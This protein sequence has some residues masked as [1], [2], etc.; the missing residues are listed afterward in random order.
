MENQDK[1]EFLPFNGINQFM[2][3]EYRRQVLQTVFGHMDQLPPQQKSRLGTLFRRYLQLPGF[4]NPTLAPMGV[5]VRGA[6]APFEKSA[7]F[8]SAILA[9]WAELN[10]E[11][12]SQIYHMLKD[13]GWE[14]LPLDADRTKVP[15]FLT[16]WPAEE[17]YEV[18]N[19]T[20]LEQFPQSKASEDDVRL[21]A[22]WISGRL[23]FEQ[24]SCKFYNWFE[25][26]LQ[27]SKNFRLFHSFH[28]DR[29]HAAQTTQVTIP[30]GMINARSASPGEAGIPRTT[31]FSRPPCAKRK[32]RS[33]P[34]GPSKKQ[35]PA[36]EAR[37]AHGCAPV[38]GNDLM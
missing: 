5:K 25:T 28:L 19:Q 4:R 33:A 9:G 34:P 29:S 30:V 3:P 8:A 1:V 38:S 21:M 27:F 26:Q 31:T 17:T 2:L 22:V 15:G 37:N 12:M 36:E 6:V 14:L 24:V 10:S 7:E 11:L 32:K 35:R 23:P 20:Y 18:L 13:R 16:R